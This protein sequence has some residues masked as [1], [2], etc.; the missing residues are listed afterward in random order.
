MKKKEIIL[1]FSSTHTLPPSMHISMADRPLYWSY[2][3]Y[4]HSRLYRQ[5]TL[6]VFGRTDFVPK[7]KN[8]EGILLKK[9]DRHYPRLNT[10][11][12]TLS[13]CVLLHFPS[14][15]ILFPFFKIFFSK[16][17]TV[18]AASADKSTKILMASSFFRV[19]LFLFGSLFDGVSHRDKSRLVWLDSSWRRCLILSTS[20]LYKKDWCCYYSPFSTRILV[21]LLFYL[22]RGLSSS[23][24]LLFFPLFFSLSLYAVVVSC[25]L[26]VSGNITLAVVAR[27]LAAMFVVVFFLFPNHSMM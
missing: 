8:G 27:S 24:R 22:Y 20:K 16:A 6:Q 15:F 7:E 5:M 9:G 19:C 1:F 14:F 21:F 26:L 10:W 4:T 2:V 13:S 3:C 23:V 11:P 18:L 12:R 17:R 25:S